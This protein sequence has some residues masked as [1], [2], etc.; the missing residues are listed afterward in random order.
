AAGERIPERGAPAATC[1]RDAAA[2]DRG[3]EGCSARI[4]DDVTGVCLVGHP[5]RDAQVRVRAQVVLD[6]PGRTLGGHDQVDAQGTATLGDVDHAVD[7][8]RHLTCQR[9]ELV[10]H[11]H[12]RGRALRVLP[13][14]QLQQVLG[15]LPVEQ[16]LPVVQLGPQAGQRTAYQVRAQVGDQAHAV[17]QV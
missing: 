17:R 6:H 7:E 14:L 9:G 12:Q 1:L 2:G 11:Q 10:D 13:L 5:Q 4:V 8:L 3:A 16:V 15:L